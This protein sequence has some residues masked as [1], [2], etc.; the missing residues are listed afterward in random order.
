[1]G[2][3]AGNNPTYEL[4]P[5]DQIDIVQRHKD[6]QESMGLT[7]EEDY[8]KLPPMHWTTKMDKEP[9]SSRFII[10]S[11]NSSVKPLGKCI[12]HIFKVIFHHK[13]RYYRKVCFYSGLKHF[14]RVDKNRYRNV[15]S[16]L[17]TGGAE[18]QD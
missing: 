3:I 1:M 17:L 4:V 6:F 9:I 10:C 15:P 13:K 5:E 11:K 8:E 18:K 16:M 2:N 7:L 12:T 14:W